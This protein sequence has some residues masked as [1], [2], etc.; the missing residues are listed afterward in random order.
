MQNT[1]I[2]AMIARRS[3]RAFKPEQIGADE[4]D[5]I[6]QAG[7]YAASGRGMQST[8]FVVVQDKATRDLLARMNAEYL[9][10]DCDPF[11]GAPTI[12]AVLAD[13]TRATCVEDGSLAIGN[14]ML[15][16]Y[17]IGLGSC[18]IHRAR[19]VFADPRGQELLAK[20]GVP[21]N[22][23]GVGHCALGRAAKPLPEPPARNEGRVYRV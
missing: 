14:L 17:S 11:Y 20:W 1:I 18:W 6:L 2:D 4:L 9:G 8:R 13:K 16:A 15:A 3:V 10:A 22:F 23:I 7:L 21:P 12:I 19:E 5:A